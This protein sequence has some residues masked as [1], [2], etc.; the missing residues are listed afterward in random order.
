MGALTS[1]NSGCFLFTRLTAYT[2]PVFLHIAL[3]TT[4]NAPLHMHRSMLNAR[5]DR[6]SAAAV[7]RAAR[8]IVAVKQQTF[9]YFSHRPSSP[10]RVK[11]SFTLPGVSRAFSDGMSFLLM[12]E[13]RSLEAC[14]DLPQCI[15]CATLSRKPRV[16]DKRRARRVR[17]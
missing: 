14:V 2:V 7:D 5:D 6:M 17:A 15:F 13:A 1:V 4:E 11:W 10:S 9:C 16:R 8:R 3:C 12:A